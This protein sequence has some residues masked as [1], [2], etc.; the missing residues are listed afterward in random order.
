MN[1][2]L[3]LTDIIDFQ[4]NVPKYEKDKWIQKG[5]KQLSDGLGILG[6][7]DFLWPLFF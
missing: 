1:L 2:P 4:V 6:Q 7:M 5:A 3:S